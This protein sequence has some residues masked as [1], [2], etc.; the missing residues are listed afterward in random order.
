MNAT[1]IDAAIGSRP[2]RKPFASSLSVIIGMSVSFSLV[3][4][5]F[6]LCLLRPAMAHPRLPSALF[7]VRARH[8]GEARRQLRGKRLVEEAK[9]FTNATW[10]NAHLGKKPD[11]VVVDEVLTKLR[12]LT[13]QASLDGRP[14]SFLQ[15]C[16]RPVGPTNGRQTDEGD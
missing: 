15:P 13:L 9:V 5:L 3:S 1:S 11:H 16:S 4:L 8:K 2:L 12:C 7:R 6:T 14:C 10:L